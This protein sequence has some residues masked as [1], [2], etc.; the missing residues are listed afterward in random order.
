MAYKLTALITLL[1]LTAVPALAANQK[2]SVNYAIYAGGIHAMNAQL[3]Y[4]E[5]SGLFDSTMQIKPVGWVGKLLPW[6]GNYHTKGRVDANGLLWPLMHDNESSWRDTRDITRLSFNAKGQLTGVQQRDYLPNGQL[7]NAYPINFAPAD[8][9]SVDIMTAPFRMLLQTGGMLKN[10]PASCN[11][12]ETVFDGKHR[13]TLQFKAQKTGTVA[14]TKYNNYAGAYQKCQFEVKPLA[15][16]EGKPRGFFAMQEESRK[17]G[18]LPF[19]WLA[20]IR[21]NT[22]YMPVRMELKSGY[23]TVIMHFQSATFQ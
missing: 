3:V 5:H 23:G 19:L 2:I 8:A 12:A 14:K 6:G 4:T 11:R 16:F 1:A 18:T 9:Q 17:L 15:G 10:S 7:R 13:Y 21:P 20:Q 22:P